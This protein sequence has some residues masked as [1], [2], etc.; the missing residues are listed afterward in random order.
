MRPLAFSSGGI[1]FWGDGS[2]MKNSQYLIYL[3]KSRKDRDI[4]NTT[5][6]M[7][8]LKRHRDALL[9]IAEENGYFIG[10]IY[11]EVVSGDTIAERP[12]MQKLL[13]AVETGLYAGVL[14][15]EVPR[16]ARGNTRD[17]GVVAETFQYSGTKIITPER[18]YDPA[19]DS[20]EE[21]F[22][23]GLFMSRREYKSINRRQQ[24]GRLVSLNEGKYIAGCAPFGYERVKLPKQKGW[25]LQIVSAEAEIV[26]LIFSLYTIGELQKE[27]TI[28]KY[29]SY[30]IANLLNERG[31]PSP[32]GK[33]WS[34]S[35]IKEIL[36][37]PTYAGYL[38]WGYRAVEKRM[39][40]GVVVE[41]RPI[42]AS[43]S[44]IE[45]LH[46]P[47][48][49][50]ETWIE[51]CEIRKS[52]SHAPLPTRTQLSNPLAG[53]LYCS[54]C[55]RS[56][57]ALPQKKNDKQWLL[58]K[59]PSAKCP[60][61][62]S[63]LPIIEKNLLNALNHWLERYQTEP[64]ALV[65]PEP[66]NLEILEKERFRLTNEL[67][68]VKSQQKSLYDLLEQG[69]Y[70]KELFHERCS[71]LTRRQSKLSN[72]IDEIE[73]RIGNERIIQNNQKLIIPNIKMVL[74]QYD[75]LISPDA[76]NNLLKEIVDK[77]IYF[78]SVGG[79]WSQSDLTLYLF[80]KLQSPQNDQ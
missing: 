53:L 55:G 35:G 18:I 19:D 64:S 29:G 66:R 28:R 75:T 43:A 73:L 42:K 62:S 61:V 34:A 17:Q 22:E 30:T 72:A 23:F 50:L 78:K 8:T 56:L 41:S 13:K 32:R 49:S 58:I 77:V 54:I 26:R 5:G 76:K 71:S 39:L 36:S 80:P 1:P 31:I 57:V 7:D 68:T 79:R 60:M 4:E 47:V 11:E 51:A 59:C 12:E 10:H 2:M 38:R 67:I 52:R 45:G 14:V 21:Y 48:I 69:I 27:G 6:V 65:K 24:R 3:R 46:E 33:L 44:Q 70:N 63:P 16:L 15:M 9:H 20:D 25:T 74:S 37:N 40:D